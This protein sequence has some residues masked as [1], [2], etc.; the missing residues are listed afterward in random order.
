LPAAV[1]KRCAGPAA[2]PY[3]FGEGTAPPAAVGI[4]MAP[5]TQTIMHHI[6]TVANATARS[7]DRDQNVRRLRPRPDRQPGMLDSSDST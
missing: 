4:A 2:Y 6:A 7:R 1:P 3:I 5:G